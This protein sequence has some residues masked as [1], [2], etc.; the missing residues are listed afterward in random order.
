MSEVVH[1]NWGW[2]EVLEEHYGKEL[3]SKVKVLVVEPGCST[4]L[5]YHNHRNE[6]WFVAEGEGVAKTVPL[7]LELYAGRVV[8][9]YLNQ[10]HQITNTGKDKL[11]IYEIQ[12]GDKCEEEDIVRL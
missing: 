11:V 8:N 1:R 9:V 3:H 4:S 2:Y 6:L 12:Y 5:Q 10:H 7:N